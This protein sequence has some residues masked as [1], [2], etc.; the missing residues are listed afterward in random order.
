V[1]NGAHHVGQELRG[2][3]IALGAETMCWSRN[4]AAR[5]GFSAYTGYPAAFWLAVK[6]GLLT[7]AR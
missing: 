7:R 1:G 6:T 2:G 4:R 3:R 5:N